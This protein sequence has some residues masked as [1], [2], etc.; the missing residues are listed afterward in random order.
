[1]LCNNTEPISEFPIFTETPGIV[2]NM[3]GKPPVAFF[4]LL[5]DENVK[6]VIWRET[7]R[8]ADQYLHNNASYLEEHPRAR[9]NQWQ[10]HPM[11]EKEVDVYLSTVIAMGIVGLPTIR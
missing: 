10:R 4:N 11:T 7:Q 8:Y 6:S 2:P 9:A 5:L 3:D 1:M